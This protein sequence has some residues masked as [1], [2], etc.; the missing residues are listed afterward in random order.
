MEK[1]RRVMLNLLLKNK[2][3]ERLNSIRTLAFENNDNEFTRLNEYLSGE[4]LLGFEKLF[5]DEQF[6]EL[7]SLM[8]YRYG[9]IVKKLEQLKEID[10]ELVELIQ[11]E[12]Q[13]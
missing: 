7:L 3:L 8:K 4:Q 1:D 13:E 11:E 2:L 6:I 10:T 12:L 9:E 5:N